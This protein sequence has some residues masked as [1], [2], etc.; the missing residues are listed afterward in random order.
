LAIATIG[1]SAGIY[2]LTKDIFATSIIVIAGI[3]VGVFA[4]RKPRQLEYELS[5]SGLQIG[6]KSYNYSLFRTFSVIK[7][8]SLTS[9]V[10]LPAK[11]FMP[12]VSAYIAAED[13]EKITKLVGEH[14]PYEERRPDYT[15]RLSRRLRF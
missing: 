9:I 1:L 5:A 6:E 7:E 12:L 15:E 4:G 10:L 13:E 14:L 2:F 11:R 8:G 3:I